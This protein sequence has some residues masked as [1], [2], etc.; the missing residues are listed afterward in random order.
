M[1]EERRDTAAV[2]E[3][4][5]GPRPFATSES[6]FFM[7]REKESRDIR[8]LLL[9][10]QVIVLYSKSGS[11]KS[12]LVNAGVIPLLTNEGFAVLPVARVSGKLPPGVDQSQISNIFAFNLLSSC[13]GVTKDL[14]VDFGT[15]LGQRLA[16]TCERPRLL[17][18]D[19]FEEIFTTFVERWRDRKPFFLQMQKL[20]DANKNL[21]IL[22]A[23]REDH[24]A[25]MDPYAESLPNGLR[26]RYRLERLRESEALRAIVV[27]MKMAGYGFQESVAENLVTNLRKIQVQTGD[28]V[29]EVAGEFVEPMHL[30]VVCRN[31][32]NGLSKER[33]TITAADM[34]QF[35]D[36]DQTLSS[37][38]G[39]AVA[40]AAERSRVRES[41]IRAWA[42]KKLVTPGG[43][44]GL[45]YMGN[46]ST[47][48]VP[49]EA[50]RV[51]EEEHIVWAEPRMGTL[52]YEL[53]HDRL[54]GPLKASN[55]LWFAR[56]RRWKRIAGILM[57]CA[58]VIGINALVY[59][60]LKH[61]ASSL[62]VMQ[63]ES[64]YFEVSTA[65]EAMLNKNWNEAIKHYESALSFYI[66]VRDR[67]EQADIY[68][69]IGQAYLG[70]NDYLQA[71]SA[72]QQARALHEGLG[73]KRTVADDIMLIAQAFYRADD[74]Q[75]A[76]NWYATAMVLYEQLGISDRRAAALERL[77]SVYVDLA[78]YDKAYGYLDEALRFYQ[79]LRPPQPLQEAYVKRSL[80]NLYGNRGE[81]DL[82]LS[83]N[84]QI[85]VTFREN[86]DISN[87]A[88]TTLGIGADQFY[89][90]NLSEAERKYRL[91]LSMFL[92]DD[93]KA[94]QA[95]VAVRMAQWYAAKH[96]CRESLDSAGRANTLAEQA[97]AADQILRAKRVK[98]R[99]YL[100]AG[101][102][103]DAAAEAQVALDLSTKRPDKWEEA[104]SLETLALVAEASGDVQG[105]IERGKKAVD[106]YD[107]IDSRTIYAKEARLNLARWLNH[108]A[109]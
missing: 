84:R 105:A 86:G 95:E 74:Y 76:G 88:W 68:N 8:D 106:V 77:G 64:A 69:E 25:E 53:T 60:H 6:A 57:V 92:R 49:N 97:N 10:Y 96:L 107:S 38:Y 33:T 54:I 78:D 66:S 45:V 11:G 37:F 32:W 94:G 89:E 42:E 44:R 22:F 28:G 16:G 5:P 99:A 43:T 58:V 63:D 82:A 98:A 81:Y 17:V 15:E 40:R 104:F 83:L 20:C 4:Y 34:E 52:W 67:G 103:Q 18:L 79:E 14:T 36:V 101:A 21:R 47:E 13:L 91:A 24:L 9:S 1:S 100:C 35:A 3:P 61:R 90:G 93:N 23:I 87:E 71:A 108:Y 59:L 2:S 12:S 31:L 27:P 30:Q 73:D 109:Q 80:V 48:G 7:G 75:N 51:L 39:L 72:H 85:L 62:R 56:R 70:K 65:K 55:R 46:T 26:I 41:R 50:V 29:A 102:L 19:Q